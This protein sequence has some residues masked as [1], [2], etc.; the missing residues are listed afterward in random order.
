M[1]QLDKLVDKTKPWELLKTDSKKQLEQF[2]DQA[3]PEILSIAFWL[4]P[5]V[6]KTTE[7]IET[8]FTA[9]KIQAPKKPLF[10]RI[11]S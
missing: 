1:G 4:K 6:P 2:F 9:E 7:K 3:I 8:I 10:P 5:F 11:K